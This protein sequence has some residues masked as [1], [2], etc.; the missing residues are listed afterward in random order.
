VSAFA[1][2]L[3]Y[4]RPNALDREVN[5]ISSA[6]LL[7]RPATALL[8]PQR[9]AAAQHFEQ[10]RVPLWIVMVALQIGVLAWFWSSG[11]SARLRDALRTRLPSEF[12][13]RFW[14]GALVALLDKCAAL[15]PQF[16]LFR[17]TRSM[18]LADIL[19]RTWFLGWIEST[20]V[21]MV[22]AGAIAAGVLWLA[23]RTHQWYL[24]TIAAVIG[25][26]LLIA[27]VNPYVIAPLALPLKPLA[28][29]PALR[30]D[31]AQLQRRTGIRVPIVMETIEQ[32]TRLGQSFVIGWG[33]SQRI[34]ISDTLLEGATEPEL[35][36]V[37]ARWFSWVASNSALHVAL[38]QGAM[39]VLGT[40]LAVFVADRIGFRRDDDPVS[41]LALLGAIMG[42]VYLLGLP[43]YNGYARNL[44][45]AADN[46]A[47]AL[48]G[49][50]AGAIRLEV[51]RADQALVP[52]CPPILS[53]WYLD[54]RPGAG[55]LISDLQQRSNVCGQGR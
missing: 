47:I 40:A 8:D 6:A 17:L 31:R 55:E 44:D 54:R 25:F 28:A 21:A 46:A 29:S 27:Y 34:V 20:I 35:R 26:T 30:A 43:F 53:S 45:I 13:V 52:L 14:F 22:V 7:S 2:L 36:F 24:Y 32:Q 37:L 9:L 23:D 5:A 49:D 12:L 39:I 18:D 16:F 33:G 4:V 51:R 50:R 19:T 38:V 41:R 42:C 15:V 10:V 1:L 11:W 48:T 3:A